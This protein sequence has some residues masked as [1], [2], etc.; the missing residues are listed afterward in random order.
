[1]HVNF[2]NYFV[3]VI[4]KLKLGTESQGEKSDS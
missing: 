1:M 2:Q 3:E 4:Y